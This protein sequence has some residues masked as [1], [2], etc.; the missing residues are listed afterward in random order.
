MIKL[1]EPSNG[2]EPLYYIL[3]NT[4]EATMNTT[5]NDLEEFQE[6]IRIDGIIY[7]SDNIVSGEIED[8]TCYVLVNELSVCGGESKVI[9]NNKANIL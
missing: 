5:Y 6:A 2:K 4:S 8:L 7:G 9:D 3:N 1:I